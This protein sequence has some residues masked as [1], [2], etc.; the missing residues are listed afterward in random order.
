[1]TNLTWSLGS[2][3]I[4]FSAVVGYFLHKKMASTDHSVLEV[5]LE[6]Q[7]TSSQPVT[8]S[9]PTT[10]T[11]TV[12]VA[13][14]GQIKPD[15]GNRRGARKATRVLCDLSGLTLAQ[16]NDICACIFQESGFLTN[17]RPNQNKDKTTGKVWSTDYGIVQVNDY[18]NIGAGKA[19][20]T[21]EYVLDNPAACVQ[22]MIN[23][24][25]STGALQPWSSWTSGAYKQWLD[26]VSTDDKFDALLIKL[27]L[28][29]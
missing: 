7:N 1:M 10:T 26:P 21:V 5:P 25:K 22:W 17:P 2:L 18:Y 12:P 23:I 4:I 19:F 13:S 8:V 3:V 14:T 20:S 27:N 16:K 9:N 28:L 11:P 15:W 29:G 6:P 24:Y